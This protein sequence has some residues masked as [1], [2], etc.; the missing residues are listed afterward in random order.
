MADD[1]LPTIKPPQWCAE[2]FVCDGSICG[3]R[4]IALQF[5]FAETP[6]AGPKE[7]LE[8]RCSTCIAWLLLCSLLLLQSFSFSILF[9][10]LLL[11]E[12]S[13]NIVRASTQAWQTY[14]QPSKAAA[15]FEV[16]PTWRAAAPGCR[17]FLWRKDASWR[18]SAP[19]WRELDFGRRDSKWFEVKS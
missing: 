9:T 8:S 19:E 18:A 14:D 5:R 16:E 4:L 13:I 7:A 10:V 1:V 11:T 12:L 2:L 6:S 3:S 15:P 17:S